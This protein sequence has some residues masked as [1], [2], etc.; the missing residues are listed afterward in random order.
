VA[1]RIGFI[2]FI[3]NRAIHGWA[4]DQEEPDQPVL[5]ELLLDEKV[6]GSAVAEGPRQDLMKAQIGTGRHGFVFPIPHALPVSRGSTISVRFAETDTQLER[7]G[8]TVGEF[9]VDGS[10]RFVEDSSQ[11][12]MLAEQDPIW[13]APWLGRDE[14][15]KG[16]DT[17]RRDFFRSGAQYVKDR[18]GALTRYY[19][20]FFARELAID[21]G[22]GIGRLTVPL[23]RRFERVIGVDISTT[24]IGLAQAQC[25]AQGIDNVEFCTAVEG[26]HELAGGGVDLVMSALTLQY[27]EETNGRQ[28]LGTLV[29]LLQDGGRGS[30]H[31]LANNLAAEGDR[32]RTSSLVTMGDGEPVEIVSYVYDIN[33]IGRLLQERGVA[34]FHVDFYR[35]GT[36]LGWII[37]FQKG[38]EA[39]P[40]P[41]IRQR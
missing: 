37:G 4:F 14:C 12:D 40:R 27:I 29:D 34:H 31:V 21:F 5:V 1:D 22:C 3:R 16:S 35:Q 36:E 30:L 28:I 20:P 18:L 39:V 2:D 41:I 11:K 15:S 9:V 7:S 6:I 17:F 24:M 33:A 38:R 19:G 8:T 25:T 10:V 13:G 23:A 26:L 32:A